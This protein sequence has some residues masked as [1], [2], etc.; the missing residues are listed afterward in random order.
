MKEE[1]GKL[2]GKKRQCFYVSH[3]ACSSREPTLTLGTPSL[4]SQR[5]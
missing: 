4:V 1:Q 3:R 5:P 2:E